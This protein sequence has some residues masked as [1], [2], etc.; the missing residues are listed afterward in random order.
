MLTKHLLIIAGIFLFSNIYAQ[1]GTEL[2]EEKDID[3]KKNAVDI[4]P[5][6]PNTPF[7]HIFIR[8]FADGN[9]DQI[10]DLKGILKQL[11]HIKNMGAGAIMIS[12]I[13]PSPSYHKYDVVNYRE[14]DSTCGTK[15]DLKELVKQAHRSGI[16]IILDFV[17]NHTSREHEWFRQA[18]NGDTVFRKYYLFSTNP[19]DWEKEP[20][21]WHYTGKNPGEK[22]YGHF[23][24]DMPDL[25]YSNRSVR[26]AMIENAKYWI[27]EY[28]IDGYRLDAAP[29]IFPDDQKDSTYAWWKEFSE[30]LK[31]EKK[32]VYLVGEVWDD[33][34]NSEP[35]L[36][37]GFTACFN[38][39]LWGMIQQA[40]NSQ[41]ASALVGS[42]NA[43][44]SSF[45]TM[46][47]GFVDATFLSNHDN[48]RIMN[49]VGGN[50]NKAK[51][52]ATIL[53][54]LPGSP[55]I[56][57]GDEI[58]MFGP[59]PDESIREPFLWDAGGEESPNAMWQK[60]TNNQPGT[61]RSLLDQLNDNNSI[62]NH[63]KQLAE[64]RSQNDGL[65]TGELRPAIEFTQPGVLAYYRV[66]KGQKL[67]VLHNLTENPLTLFSPKGFVWFG[68]PYFDPLAQP[69]L[70]K[71]NIILQ[72]F[73]SAVINVKNDE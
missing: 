57:Y 63:Y 41:D 12:P 26:K 53:F 60:P 17:A 68:M 73:S 10:G 56:Y 58:G 1:K 13:H 18:L 40:L 45:K 55:F 25:N 59:K 7:Y 46:N 33:A 44:R 34:K 11:G 62:Y 32:D 20:S 19:S 31:K 67:L 61:T 6:F 47:K 39:Q 54:T 24:K 72:P 50:I 35:Y 36:R 64:I 14:I 37:S 52:A 16:L 8:S 15:E 69:V 29:K 4:N 48:P 51:Q 43:M 21:A 66:T 65:E 27:K 28:N 30:A 9:K 49:V 2:P 70:S 71:D 22:Y 23:S 3:V 5:K 42:L 38:F